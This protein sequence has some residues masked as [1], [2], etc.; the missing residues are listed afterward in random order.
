[1]LHFRRV[2]TLHP[3]APAAVALLAGCM[4]GAPADQG[5]LAGEVAEVASASSMDPDLVVQA[6]SGPP[7]AMPGTFI[8]IEVEVC[9]QGG[10][11]A[12]ASDVAVV[13]SEDD[14]IDELD[15]VLGIAPV[16][17]LA[18]GG[19]RRVGVFGAAPGVNGRH[20]LGA[21][22]DFFQYVYEGDETNNAAAGSA[23]AV[24][25][26]PDL[27]VERVRGPATAAPGAQV[28]IDVRVCNR[29]Q[30]PV[31]GVD[32]ELYLSED[33]VITAADMPIGWVQT[34]YLEPGDCDDTTGTASFW[35]DPGPHVLGAIVDP[36]A[37]ITELDEDNNARA[38]G[39]LHIGWDPDLVIT[40]ID[41]P[42]SAMPG[43]QV[44]VAVTACN[45][46]QAPSGFAEIVIHVSDDDQLDP[47]VDPMVG[48]AFL[49]DLQPGAC[50][51]TQASVSLYYGPPG[52]VRLGAVVDPWSYVLEI[53][54]DNNSHLG[55]RVG[56]GYGPD[57]VV[58]GVSGPPSSW[59]YEDFQAA[60]RVCNQ[61]QSHSP[62]TSVRIHMEDDG[63]SP[64]PG[65]TWVPPLAPG[66]CA[67]AFGP[68]FAP[69]QPGGY[70]LRATVD[71]EGYVDELVESNNDGAGQRVAVG[72]DADLVVT[73]VT[74]PPGVL[75]Q[76]TT[77]VARVCNHGRVVSDPAPV[78]LLTSR[79][80]EPSSNDMLA[81]DGYVSWL[82]PDACADLV[83]PA[84]FFVP[85]EGAY[86]LIAEV[87][88]FDQVVE[89]LDDN[90][91]GASGVVGIGHSADLVVTAIAA[92]PS[93]QPGA[94]F[95]LGVTVCNRGHMTSGFT[96]VEVMA[97]AEGQNAGF[98]EVHVGWAP[99][100]HLPPGQCATSHMPAYLHGPSGGH[101]LRAVLD[102]WNSVQE[103]LESNN[104]FAG[105]LIGVGHD[106]DL[107]V[108]AISGPPSAQPGVMADVTVRVCNQGQGNSWG[109][110]VELYFSMDHEIGM[111]SDMPAGWGEVGQLAPGDC[112]DVVVPAHAP[113]E[114]GAYVL[115]AVVDPHGNIPEL[116]ES[117]NAVVGE[118]LGIGW[119][120]DLV[121]AS[122]SG[123][124]SAQPWSHVEVS[125]RVCNQGQSTSWYG[126]LDLVLSSD[127]VVG[128]GDMVIGG[129]PVPTLEPGQC[130]DLTV[131][132]PAQ[133]NNGVYTL[134]AVV[135]A[136]GQPELIADNNGRAGGLL[137]VGYDPDLIVTAVTGPASAPAYSELMVTVEACNQGQ[138]E[139]WG[140]ILDVVLSSD[141]AVDNTDIPV[142]SIGLDPLA[143][144]ACQTVSLPVW[145]FQ[146]EGS[147]VLGARVDPHGYIWEL[148]ESNNATAG[149]AIELTQPY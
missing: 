67:N 4:S 34:G 91:A 57:L 139:A 98:H 140:G 112:A 39:T 16:W 127:A 18:P 70:V 63:L 103:V 17:D 23:L 110:P 69:G 12:T 131:V 9:N 78:R 117:N 111:P 61:G 135:R 121:V 32:V 89:I 11:W 100:D 38:G 119:E 10:V 27:V 96:D 73:S 148:I 13:A 136:D 55:E 66:A 114:P 95:E 101:R 74:P 33:G 7:S 92:P 31:W 65:M 19:C 128:S 45:Q 109:T 6:V 49:P 134:G 15:P 82:A 94:S 107:V 77:V 14:V 133:V 120:P 97:M 106:A 113:W 123:P 132:A 41:G 125:A 141:P 48:Y 124:P 60:A 93:V 85:E 64:Y 145:P 22:A 105:G 142:G 104:D 62:G 87:D 36:Y 35:G 54:E 116:I 143:P 144:G 40:A 44:S 80:A 56:V 130:H 52:G 26:E 146:D 28:A 53:I 86:H 8:E 149:T 118:R 43:Q 76:Q 29:G 25:Y 20:V 5:P 126:M 115:G 83:F 24:G 137:G 84:H 99:V 71:P 138:G 42:P 30:S 46:G 129:A 51:T 102:R 75:W 68:V 50:A 58:A 72:Q 90:N 147:Y 3:A 122:V 79:D 37:W 59:P 88:P 21:R 47:M 108:S 1:M 2:V 81:G